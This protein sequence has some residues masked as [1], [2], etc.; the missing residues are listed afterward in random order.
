MLGIVLAAQ[1]ASA[2]VNPPPA[3]VRAVELTS[4]LSLSGGLRCDQRGCPAAVFSLA[5]RVDVLYRPGPRAWGIGPFLSTRTDNFADIAPALGASL[6]VPV[7]ESLP[8][9]LSAGGAV[10]VDPAGVSGGPIE[11]VWWGARSY[12]FHTPYVLSLGVFA[13]ARQLAIGANAGWDVVLGIDADLEFLAIPF[14]A[15]YTWAFR[16][17]H[18]R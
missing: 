18:R 15:I 11:R 5:L 9:V 6:L 13:E 17:D 2:S 4:Q 16:A 7:S 3:A 12:N 8:F 1:L 10:R 14:M